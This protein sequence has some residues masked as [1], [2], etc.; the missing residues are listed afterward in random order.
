MKFDKILQPHIV[1]EECQNIPDITSCQIDALKSLYNIPSHMTGH[2]MHHQ[3][4]TRLERNPEILEEQNQLHIGSDCCLEI[5]IHE[6]WIMTVHKRH[7]KLITLFEL[8]Q[9]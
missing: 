2:R 8:M 9:L 6:V 4:H 5:S 1:S 7:N 3:V